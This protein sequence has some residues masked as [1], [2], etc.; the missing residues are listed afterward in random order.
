MAARVEKQKRWIF[1]KPVLEINSMFFRIAKKCV[2][3][4]VFP[5]CCALIT[6]YI[7]YMVLRSIQEGASHFFN[8]SVLFK[9]LFYSHV[10]Y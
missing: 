2:R 5:V 9:F 10:L 7:L 6:H 8:L 3:I 1:K 4:I